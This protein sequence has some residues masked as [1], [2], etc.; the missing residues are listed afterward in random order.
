MLRLMYI[1]LSELNLIAN[2]T[3]GYVRMNR[4][5]PLATLFRACGAEAREKL[6]ELHFLLEFTT[7][8]HAR[9][10]PA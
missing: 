9:V 7:D 10:P 6:T 3:R 2:I 8:N 5:L 4:D 1:A